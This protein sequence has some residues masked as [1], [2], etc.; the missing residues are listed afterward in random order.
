MT[1]VSRYACLICDKT[2]SSQYK[3]DEVRYNYMCHLGLRVKNRK[4]V[5]LRCPHCMS[6][7]YAQKDDKNKRHILYRYHLYKMLEGRYK[8]SRQY[9]PHMDKIEKYCTTKVKCKTCGKVLPRYEFNAKPDIKGDFCLHCRTCWA[10]I[11]R[12]RAKKYKKEG[13]K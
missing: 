4:G 7:Y 10:D 2:F 12:E 5:E 9:L 6:I 3:Y 13:K 1:E 8:I 11:E